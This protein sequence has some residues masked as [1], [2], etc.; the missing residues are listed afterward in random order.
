MLKELY[1]AGGDLLLLLLMCLHGLVYLHELLLNL[2]VCFR[3]G[4]LLFQRLQ[5]MWLQD[6][7]LSWVL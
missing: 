4:Y 3:L 2:N 6:D 1:I 5:E 7:L